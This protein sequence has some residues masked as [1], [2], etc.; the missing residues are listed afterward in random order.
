MADVYFLTG[1]FESCLG[2]LEI[3]VKFPDS[4]GN[5]FYHLR[6]GQSHFELGNLEQATE[7]LLRAYD[8]KSSKIFQHDDPKYFDFLKSQVPAPIKGWN[9]K[10][11]FFQALM[12]K[13]KP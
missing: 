7:N 11:N 1:E 3:L 12:R 6:K 10:L 2:I 5:P 13:F 9:P 4:V 8:L